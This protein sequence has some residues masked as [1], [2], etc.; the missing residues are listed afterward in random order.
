MRIAHVTTVHPRHDIR[1]FRKECVSLARAGYE[2][3]L[4][5]GDGLGDEARDGVR[6]VDIGRA[7][8]GRLARMREQPLRAWHAL[9]RIDPVSVHFH[10]PELLR[11]GV[12]LAR[13]G[14]IAIYDAHEDVPRQIL[15]KQWIPAP[16][17]RPLAWAFEHYEDALVR[18]LSAVVAATPH[19]AERFARQRV[20]AV[21]VCNFPLTEEL[22]APAEGGVRENAVCY[23]GSITR[24]RGIRELMAAL[25]L[26]PQVRLV[27]CGSFEDAALEAEL[28]AHA[29][30]PQ[31][32][33]R[34]LVGRD[35]VRDAMAQV[36]VGMVTLLPMPS[37]MDALP[38]K[39]FE[40]MSAGLPVIASNFPLWRE[41]V[42]G[43][44]CGLCVDPTDAR[45]T[46]NAIRELL[47][48]PQAAERM[49]A[50]GREAVQRQFNWPHEERELLDFYRALLAH[51]A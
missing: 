12:R 6:I 42:E 1:I 37:Y 20:R 41:I 33:Y 47:A 3:H 25:A 24:T 46:A 29:A 15:T 34:G 14:R 44:Q 21:S 4:V 23:I 30:W 10:D 32:D 50:G 9:Q 45:A 22:S 5:V 35:G 40:Y 11:I 7:P 2:V 8:A 28:R 39:M 16:L 48:S 17:R 51:R 19:I 43:G 31:V 49:G 26:L 38:I 36:R 18:R 27:L 13:S